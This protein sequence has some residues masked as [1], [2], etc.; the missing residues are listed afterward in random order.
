MPANALKH[1]H[2][3]SREHSSPF[4]GWLRLCVLRLADAKPSAWIP[5]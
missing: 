4:L 1:V 5:S 3:G 2:G